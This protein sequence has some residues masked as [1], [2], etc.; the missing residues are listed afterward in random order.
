MTPR[1][2]PAL[3]LSRRLGFSVLVTVGLLA[4]LE[5]VAWLL[6]SSLT[7]RREIVLSRPGQGEAMVANEDVPGWDLNYPE[8]W[9]GNQHYTT[10]QW[11]MRGPEHPVEKPANAWRVIFVGDSAIFGYLL[12]W[13][14]TIPGQLE[15]LS[16]QRYGVDYQVAACAAPGHSSAQS[17]YKLSRHCLGFQPDVVVIGNRNSDGT[18]DIATDRERFQL[19][20]WSGPASLPQRLALYRLIRNRWLAARVAS[21]AS[22]TPERIAHGGDPSAPKGEFRRV[23]PEEYEE[24]LRE[25][26]R[27][28]REAGAQP[29]LL[30]L[31]VVFDL[32][33]YQL[34]KTPL[35]DEY[36]QV[37]RKVA[38][39][40]SV[41]LAD[42]PEWFARAPMVNDIFVDSVHP[43]RTGAL[44]IA[45]LLD[46]VVPGP[47]QAQ[48]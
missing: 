10:N 11:R 40:E 39:Q 19:Q 12:G 37:M 46:Q 45:E 43:G 4:L 30:L 44:F 6:P 48:R 25:M 2:R 14:D 31:P 18:M 20:A 7:A 33:W 27:L 36:N 32:P 16:E 47:P 41:P 22:D 35:N 23:P 3:P 42:G 8:G 28:S 26:I 15:R 13:P 5:G 9:L 29:V 1:T 17:V 24:N 34:Q 38:Q 21:G